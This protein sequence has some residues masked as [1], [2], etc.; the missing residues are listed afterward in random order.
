MLTFE[1]V[2]HNPN[3]VYVKYG[4]SDVATILIEEEKVIFH[5]DFNYK[6]VHYLEIAQYIK[7][8]KPV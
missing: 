7:S 5:L 6:F 4:Y 2:P 3:R 1:T 8:L